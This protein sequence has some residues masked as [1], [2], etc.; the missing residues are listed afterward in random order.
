M[1]QT[2]PPNQAASHA[3]YYNDSVQFDANFAQL[4]SETMES[5]LKILHK[6]IQEKQSRASRDFIIVTDYILK[7]FNFHRVFI[8]SNDAYFNFESYNE[9][10]QGE[11]IEVL[12]L[13]S[14]KQL[15]T[16]VKRLESFTKT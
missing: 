2:I 6:K 16:A 14:H 4:M 5:V 9:K 1:K 12:A 7:V 13:K 15:D 8:P 10:M 11:S 3:K